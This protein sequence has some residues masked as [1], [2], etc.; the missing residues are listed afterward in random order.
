MKFFNALIL[1][2]SSIAI[3]LIPFRAPNLEPILAMQMPFAKK[4][5]K[6][7]GFLFGALSILFFD[8][9]T[10]TL[11]L[12]SGIT[13][14]SYGL[15]GVFSVIFFQKFKANR[16]NYVYFAILGTIFY[17][18]T[19]GL[20][21]GPVFFGQSFSVALVGQIPFT[22]L[23]LLGNISFAFFLSPLVERA[24]IK[25]ESFEAKNIINVFSLKR[26]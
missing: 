15:L 3:R 5:G 26:I 6:V 4:Y 1:I 23:H 7:F 18:I 25:M 9:F 8:L 11:G 22:I 13:A 20:V 19:T 21:I 10:N 2:F 24:L 16:K 12:W 14:L 17:D